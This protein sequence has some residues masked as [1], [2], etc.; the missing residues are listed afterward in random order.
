[1]A[2]EFH[3]RKSLE[4]FDWS[5]NPSVPCKQVYDLASSNSFARIRTCFGRDH[6]AWATAT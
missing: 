4:D 3:E 6:R 1:M 2:T 5:F